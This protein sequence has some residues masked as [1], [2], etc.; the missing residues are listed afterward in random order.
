MDQQNRCAPEEQQ[1]ELETP[2]RP[3]EK[4]ELVVY[5]TL[6]ELTLSGGNRQRDGVFTRAPS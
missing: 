2:R 6:G 3:Y 1:A 5:G 4:P